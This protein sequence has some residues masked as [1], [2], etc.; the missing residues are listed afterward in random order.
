VAEE[1]ASRTAHVFVCSGALSFDAARRILPTL[2]ADAAPYVLLCF[3]L[4]SQT[5]PNGVKALT[6]DSWSGSEWT[7]PF[8]MARGLREALR[9][10]SRDGVEKIVAYLPHPFD[11]PGNWFA[12][13]D[14]RVTR[15]EL[16]PDGLVNYLK[17]PHRPLGGVRRLRYEVR[18]LLRRLAAACYGLRYRPLAGGH[19]TQYETIDYSSAWTDQPAGLC[20]SRGDNIR[21]LPGRARGAEHASPDEL[22]VLVVDQELH[23]LVG[24]QLER[25]LRAR[26]DEL[27]RELGVARIY[28]KAHPRGRNRSAQFGSAAQ[29][30]S[31]DTLAEE[32]AQAL[33]V[34]H[35]VGYY[36]TALLGNYGDGVQRIAILP[37]PDVHGLIKR[38]YLA[39]VIDVLRRA[40]VSLLL[41]Q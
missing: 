12:Y 1:S 23:S 34:T 13:F 24:P 35:V 2:P 21:L 7:K 19:L 41:L 30:V 4:R 20:T 33:R 26:T 40:D 3:P 31:G 37:G 28:Y 36:S 10:L 29:D 15:L 39:E 8:V 38:E 6:M 32:L 22:S 16:L 27:L 18:V 25:R 9:V 17:S 11:P 14:E 5:V